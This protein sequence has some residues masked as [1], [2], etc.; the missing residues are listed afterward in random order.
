M[1]TMLG[2]GT[3]RKGI[4]GIIYMILAKAVHPLWGSLLHWWIPLSLLLFMK[5][6]YVCNL[7]SVDMNQ[8]V[9]EYMRIHTFE[10]HDCKQ[11]NAFSRFI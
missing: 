9:L 10:F 8:Q 5:Y 4:V 2:H 3:S 7:S 6:E 11:S 1:S